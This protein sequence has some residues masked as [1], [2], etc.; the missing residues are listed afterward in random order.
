MLSTALRATFLALSANLARASTAAVSNMKGKV[1]SVVALDPTTGAVLA[2][3]SNP[4][5][6][7]N[8]IA[9][10]D[11]DTSTAAGNALQADKSKPNLNHAIGE[12][13]P[14]G[15]VFKIVTA[16]AAL[17]SGKF[18]ETGDTGGPRGALTWPGS[19]TQLKNENGETCRGADLK[20]A[21]AQSCNSIYGYV[22]D[23]LGPQVMADYATKFGFNNP[24]LKIPLTVAQ[25]N[26]PSAAQMGSDSVMLAQAS[27]GQ[28]NTQV[29]PLQAAMIAGAV[30]NGGV[31]MQPYM[32]DKE[33]APNGHVTYKGSDH[34]HE[35]SQAMQPQTAATLD[36]MMQY[37]VTD[38]TAAPDAVQGVQMGAK[39]GTAQQG[40]NKNPLA[41]F[42]CYG[43]AN[44]KK[45]AVAVMVQTSDPSI[46]DDVSGSGYAGPVAAAV[47]KAA[48]GVN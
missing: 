26:Y 4:S 21:L 45:V 3:Y 15:S 40:D 6:D 47:L 27:I 23:Q 19:A 22:A 28:N 29:T 31:I 32:V 16:A 37:V 34:Q 18:T 1:G 24:S 38:G 35:L 42:V 39:T 33:T 25:S 17:E 5:F 44:G 43:T 9:S 7:P 14:P 46:R 2:M 13:Y 20:T 41:W 30:A 48:L 8:G 12:N 36:D 10:N 11:N